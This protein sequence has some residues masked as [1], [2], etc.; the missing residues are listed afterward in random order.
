MIVALPI[1]LFAIGIFLLIKSADWIVDSSSSMAKKLH[2]S[3]LII[4][5]TIVAFG[6][7]LPELVINIFAS[8]E[9]ASEV[10]FGNVIGSNISNI[11]LILGITA[12][13]TNVKVNSRTVTREI[14][15]AL[16]AILVLF[17]LI[18]KIFFNN[19]NTLLWN[20]G[21]VLLAL[22]SMFLYYIYQS[23]IEDKK[24]IEL[25]EEVDIKN[26]KIAT[27]LIIGLIGIYFGGR[28]VVNGATFIA[29][30]LGLSEFLISATII[31]IGTSLPELV[32]SVMAAIKKNINLAVGNIVGSNI[33]N[34]LWVL[35]IIPLIRPLIIPSF[36]WIDIAIMFA[37]TLLLFAFMFIGPRDQLTRKDGISFIILYIIYILYLISRG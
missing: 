9:G 3:N 2:V 26:W 25:V 4:G 12:I 16:L 7:S 6:T 11:L 27:K 5:L 32:V 36:I 24:R 20:D 15:F 33:F 35:G 18:S 22:F 19:G 30:Q 14:P 13:I 23:A 1:I 17:A 10:S 29:T 37:V 34:I 31:A 28:W 8:I 21:L